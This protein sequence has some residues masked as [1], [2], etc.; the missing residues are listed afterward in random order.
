MDN[1]EFNVSNLKAGNFNINQTKMD[2]ILKMLV[3]NGYVNGIAHRPNI[4]SVQIL[5]SVSITLKG[6]EYLEENSLMQKASDVAKGIID[7]CT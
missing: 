5:D 4:N 1:E 3:D 7:V 2:K 6:L